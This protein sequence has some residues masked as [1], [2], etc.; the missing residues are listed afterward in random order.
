MT[1]IIYPRDIY[2]TLFTMRGATGITLQPHQML[3]LPRKMMRII[4]CRRI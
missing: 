3:P 1:R 2:E 4:G